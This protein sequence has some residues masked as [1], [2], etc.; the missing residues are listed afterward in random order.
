MMMMML[1]VP[2][3]TR[4]EAMVIFDRHDHAAAKDGGRGENH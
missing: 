1:V 4:L 2:M 3:M